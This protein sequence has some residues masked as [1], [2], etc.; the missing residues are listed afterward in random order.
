MNV[1]KHFTLRSLRANRKWTVVTLIGII[2]STAMIAAVSTFCTSFMELMRSEAIADNGNWHAAVSGVPIGNVSA[3][4]KAGFVDE[5]SLSHDVGYARFANAKN[6]S[7]P[8]LFICQLDENSNKI[9]PIQLTLGRMPQ[10]DR[11][12]VLSEHLET[13]GGVKYSVGDTITLD[14]GKR[15]SPEGISFGQQNAYQGEASTD[16]HGEI[17]VP[18]QTRTYTVVGIIGRPNFEPAWA[19]GYTALSFL[20]TQTLSPDDEVTVTLLSKKLNRKLYENVAQLASDLGLD[21]SHISYNTGLLRYSGIVANDS[22]QNM[23]YGFAA[24]FTVIII[25]ASVSLIYNAFA[26]SVSERMSQL[27]MLASVGATRKQ[28]RHSV[29]FE[30]FLLGIIGIPIGILA[31]IT[32]IGVT[33]SVIRPLMASFMN[34][35]SAQGLSLHVSLLS[36]A[37]AFLLAALTILASVWIPAQRSSKI[38][39]IDAIRQSKE[40]KLTGKAVKTSR[41]TRRLFGFEGEIALKNLKR[42]R[43]K[44]RATVL[45]LI[46]SLVLFL[47]VSYYAQEMNRASGAMETGYNFNL[48]VSYIN[49]PAAEA[50]EANAKI[51]ALEGVA[52]MAAAET[53]SGF[54]LMENT[55]LSELLRRNYAS[56]GEAFPLITTFYCFDNASFDRYAGSLGIDPQA[57]RNPDNPKIILVNYGQNYLNSKRIAGEILSV[58]QGDILSLSRNE[59][60][61]TGEKGEREAENSIELEVGLLT[62]QRPMG[63]LVSSLNSISAVVSREVFDSLPAS[64]KSID[65]NGNPG[66][67]QLFLNCEDAD[68]I[69]VKI[70]ELTHGVSGRRYIY[71]VAAGARSERN[72]MLVL[73]IFIY[74]FITLISLICIA[75]IFNTVTTNIALRRREFAMLRSVGMTPKSFSRMIRFESIFYGLKALLYGI[76]IS[77][78][79]SLLLHNIGSEVFEFGF[80]LPWASYGAAIV[81]ILVIVGATMLYSSSKVR[82]ENII[83]ALKT[84][85]M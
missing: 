21:E 51:A 69:E 57:Y 1:M 53:A 64:L 17:F 30:G 4:E 58:S 76:P 34:L 7:K 39:P 77:A 43:K 47:T 67:Q 33:L 56:D 68:G 22:A 83:D 85:I 31:G 18:E 26:I 80:S 50:S 3:F 55:Q 36:V 24:V 71:N 41:L 12:L 16:S 49:V 6:E 38:M 9:F 37:T 81:L 20:D 44:Y 40:I 78:G 84:E 35:S 65:S 25:I 14:I 72:M 8:Y 61:G 59:M 2:I 48:L 32:G 79:I 29:Y 60:G 19:P 52:E 23:L 46:I 82:K 54:F 11:E 70:Q 62:D 74:G 66:F 45:S 28:K 73:G 42:S 5:S 27:G 63:V 15:M 75:N 10:N 13:N